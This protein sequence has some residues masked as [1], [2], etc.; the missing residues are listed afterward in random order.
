MWML[1]NRRRRDRDLD[2]E[3]RNDEAL[4]WRWLQDAAQDIECSLRSLRSQKGFVGSVVATLALGI[5]ATTAIFSV[6]SGVILKP[7][8]FAAPDRLV[9]LYGTPAIRGEAV[10]RLPDLR[11]EA[12]SFDALVG[13]SVSARYARTPRGPERLMIV[14]AERPFF[15]M[16]GVAP[17]AGR[18]FADDDPA[19]VAVV[20]EG[21]WR[22]RLGA[23][24]GVLG[25]TLTLDDGP[26][27]IIGVM[28]DL[29]QFPYRAASLLN[30]VATEARTDLWLPLDPPAD[31]GLRARGRFSSV[32]GRLKPGVTYDEAGSELSLI[33][34]RL[35]AGARDPAGPRGVRLAPL[36]EVVVPAPIRRT[37]F[38]LFGAVGLVLIVSC[39]NVANLSVVR[40]TLRAREIAARTALGAGSARLARQF[41]TESLLLSMAGGAAGLLLAWWGLGWLLGV[42]GA[43]IP[44]TREVGLDWRV[45]A[46]LLSTCA[47]VGLFEAL[48]P[49][50]VARR[51]DAAAVLQGTSDRTT[52]GGGLRRLRDLLIVAEVAMAVVL[53]VGAAVLVREMVR[54][55]NTDTGMASTNVMTFHLGRRSPEVGVVTRGAPAAAITRPYYEI[56]ERVSG[57][58][59]VR[60]AG[61]T[62]V[63]P[64]QNWGWSANSIDFGIVGRPRLDGPAFS[65]E[66]RYVTPGYFAA[67]GIPIR[68]GRGFT[69]ADNRDA[70]PV[71]AINETLGRIAFGSDD[72]VGRVTTRGT[73]VGVLGDIRNANLDRPTLPE[74]YFPVAQNWSQLSE[75]GMTLAVRTYGPPDG[76]IDAVRAQV[77]EVD[78]EQ[79]IFNVKSLETIVIESFSSFRMFLWLMTGFAVTALVL[80]LTGTYAVIAYVSTSRTRELAIRAA[81]GADRSQMIRLVVREGV[82]LAAAGLAVGVL[83][84]LVLAPVLRGLPVSVRPPDLAITVP[85]GL[86]VAV[87]AILAALFPAW[88]A[89]GVEP[90]VALR[91]E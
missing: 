14:N 52:I 32:V 2:D 69:V 61:F 91:S 50:F 56:A 85:V 70:P 13:Y 83:L 9:Q 75:L 21:F 47:L 76:V 37:L 90:M 80:A 73:V 17:I 31:S 62:Q 64:L 57:I 16:L 29:F 71:I 1:A 44:R 22:D 24:S 54:L 46:F 33:A 81:L 15:T 48:V 65:F 51:T 18:T 55:T 41:L 77:T 27:T 34:E 26:T 63:L 19:S 10:D 39:A 23:T 84:A 89:A 82:V 49:A 60:A 20:S 35:A 43:E 87:V 68:R 79:A 59:G 12:R 58:P 72:P 11:R 74:M 88:R 78:P 53:A 40:M 7:L 38:V 25:L 42:A 45:F 8:P 28:P 3:I 86:F 6:V 30:S 67:I 66:L 36:A 5:G 4:G